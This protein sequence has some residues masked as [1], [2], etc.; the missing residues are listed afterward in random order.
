MP[1]WD[2]L[3]TDARI[4]TMRDGEPD[5]GAIEKGAIAIADGRLAWVGTEAELPGSAAA[6]S[7]SVDGRWITPALIDCH[8]HL[9]FGGDRA[10]E[11]EQRLRG[12]SYEDIARAGGGIMS[13]VRATRNETTEQLFASALPRAHALM[14]DGVATVEI[15]DT[16]YK[17]VKFDAGRTIED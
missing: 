5:Y 7:R 12:A 6:E 14:R 8:T 10:A 2:L 13:T 11:Y 4:A 17:V 16:T 1:D 9:V 15:T 3:L